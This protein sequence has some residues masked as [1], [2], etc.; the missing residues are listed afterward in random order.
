MQ[1]VHPLR[2]R[3]WLRIAVVLYGSTWLAAYR[4]FATIATPVPY[5]RFNGLR[6]KGQG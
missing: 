4:M 6:P 1:G 5:G 2:L 3:R